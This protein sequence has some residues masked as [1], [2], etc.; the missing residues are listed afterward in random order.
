[1]KSTIKVELIPL[2]AALEPVIKVKISKDNSD[3][4]DYA[5]KTFF[6]SQGFESNILV[7]KRVGGYS[8][9]EGGFEELDIYPVNNLLVDRFSE[10]KEVGI[11]IASNTED[12]REFLD[13]KKVM[14]TNDGENITVFKV[15]D[16]FKM[17]A[18]F[19]RF[20]SQRPVTN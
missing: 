15:Q 14:Y 3:V 4:R 1:M 16:L 12:I 11:R 13:A 9:P 7:V 10:T 19:E 2:G 8:G 18:D 17:G 5:L 20:R 6:E